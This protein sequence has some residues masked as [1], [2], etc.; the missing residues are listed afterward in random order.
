MCA[1]LPPSFGGSQLFWSQ[2]SIF[3]FVE[4]QKCVA[5]VSGDNFQTAGS[6]A[7]CGLD[8][9]SDR[10]G[11]VGHERPPSS[12]DTSIVESDLPQS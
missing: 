6:R 4:M 12:H 3:S 2:Y 1:L 7:D 5:F 10:R 11:V 8:P 9:I